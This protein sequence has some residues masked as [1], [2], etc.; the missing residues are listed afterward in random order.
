MKKRKG[1]VTPKKAVEAVQEEPAMETHVS[2]CSQPPPET[3]VTD[4][5][6]PE[7]LRAKVVR[8]AGNPSWVYVKFLG[9]SQVRPV[10]VP[11][12]FRH[13]LLNKIIPIEAISD[14][15]GEKTY[16]YDYSVR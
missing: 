11:R 3:A 16:R 5:L 8:L 2:V 6:R 10:A 15:T 14:A 12:R 4:V 9:D 7:K 1:K 13:S